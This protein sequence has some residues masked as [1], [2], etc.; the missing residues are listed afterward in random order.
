MKSSKVLSLFLITLALF[1]DGLLAQMELGWFQKASLPGPARHRATGISIGG[2]G[3]I[4]LGHI[5]AVVDVQYKD[6]WEY[7]PAT[8][9]WTQK[10]DYAGG[11]RYH[12]AG[13]SIGNLGYVGTGRDTTF[14]NR[15][16]FWEYNP[17][18]N[19]WTQKAMFG[20]QARRGA[21]GFSVNGRGYIGTGSGLSDFWEYNPVTNSWMQ[22]A[23]FPG[24]GRQSAVG[25][26]IGSRGYIGTGSSGGN[27]TGDLWEYNPTNNTWVQKAPLPGLPRMEACGFSYN[28]FGYVGTGD[29]F[30]SGTNYDDFWRFDPV[31]NSWVQIQDFGGTARRYLVGFAIGNRAYAGTGTNGTNFQDWW[32]YGNFTGINPPEPGAPLFSVY[33]NPIVD[34]A[35]LKTDPEISFTGLK[36]QII[37]LSGKML[38]EQMLESRETNFETGNLPAGIYFIRLI[39]GNGILST[40]KII[41]A[42]S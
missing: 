40:Q 42:G 19:T 6:W 7:D 27:P 20:G 5:N 35:T 13:F 28:G 32:E 30:S 15:R 16:D 1:P 9:S 33:P 4:G 17:V 24:G 26:S 23:S 21:V 39:T 2:R 25:F 36:F 12:A 37:S 3:Y 10:A 8:N 38:R 41:V 14:S 29:N 22:R 18:T 11:K 34:F 31:S